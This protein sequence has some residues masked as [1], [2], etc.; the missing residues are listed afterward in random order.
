MTLRILEY[1]ITTRQQQQKF[2]FFFDC[3]STTLFHFRE[4]IWEY[5][6]KGNI[7]VGEETVTQSCTLSLFLEP[8]MGKEGFGF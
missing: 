3:R 5:N 7:E 8:D 2:F 6:M 4:S 1:C